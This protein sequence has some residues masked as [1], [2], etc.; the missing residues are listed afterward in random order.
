MRRLGQAGGQ[1][2]HLVEAFDGAIQLGPTAQVWPVPQPVERARPAI[3]GDQESIEP[4]ALRGGDVACEG[5]PQALCGTCA[6]T[7]DEPF[8][9]GRAGQKHLFGHEPCGRTVEQ[10]A[11]P[12]SASPAQ[13]VQ[14]TGK[15]EPGAAVGELTIS[16]PGPD[17]AG[18]LPF[19]ATFAVLGQAP[20]VGD[21]ELPCNIAADTR[22]HIGGIVEKGAQEPHRTE[23]DGIPEPHRV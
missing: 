22:R 14:P 5:A 3:V 20:W 7:R 2:A 8:Q 4:V 1:Q 18:V 23:L 17:L 19:G 12:V 10:D 11:R 6:D 16:E 9:R 21:A 15:A 13:G